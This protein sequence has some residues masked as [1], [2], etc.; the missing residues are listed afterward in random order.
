MREVINGLCLPFIKSETS[1]LDVTDILVS[2]VEKSNIEVLQGLT[3]DEV[4]QSTLDGATLTVAVVVGNVVYIAHVGDNRAYL[5]S[6]GGIKQITRDHTI[7]QALVEHGHIAPGEAKNHDMTKVLYR[8]VGAETI[9]PDLC[10]L[11]LLP[12]S[13]LLICSDGV[14]RQAEDEEIFSTLVNHPRPQEACDKLVSLAN[15]HGG[16]DN[17]TVILV[18]ISTG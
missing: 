17:V 10:S 13:H 2:A 1:Q 18:E 8:Y 6:E 15:A 7:P 16:E 5:I 12:G 3:F 9:D 14:W 11:S 4:F